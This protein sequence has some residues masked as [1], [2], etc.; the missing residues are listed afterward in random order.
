MSNWTP[1]TEHVR[2][3]YSQDATSSDHRK[4]YETEFDRWLNKNLAK[5]FGKGY[6]LGWDEKKRDDKTINAIIEL[7]A[8]EQIFDD[9][10]C[11]HCLETSNYETDQAPY[12]CPTIQI[13]E[14]RSGK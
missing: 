10:Y 6:A 11:T 13:I 8:P 14:N 12:P 5:E 3:I 2:T 9:W 1:D 4:V 7:H